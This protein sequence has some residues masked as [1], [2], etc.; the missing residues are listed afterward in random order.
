MEVMVQIGILN[1][2]VSPPGCRS[3]FYISIAKIGEVYGGDLL[4]RSTCAAD[5]ATTGKQWSD[6]GRF[7]RIGPVMRRALAIA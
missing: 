7:W 2:Y 1:N 6:G 5:T 3:V 4:G